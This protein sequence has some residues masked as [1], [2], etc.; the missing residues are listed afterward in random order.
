MKLFLL[1]LSILA[2]G[3][4]DREFNKRVFSG[5]T[6]E[7][8]CFSNRYV[9]IKNATWSNGNSIRRCQVDLTNFMKQKCQGESNCHYEV[10]E[11]NFND[12]STGGVMRLDVKY[13]C[14]KCDDTS[15]V[16]RSDTDW[17]YSFCKFSDGTASSNNCPN[18]TF[19][20]NHICRY[21]SSEREINEFAK[22]SARQQRNN[23]GIDAITV[24]TGNDIRY[25]GAPGRD[26]CVFTDHQKKYDCEKRSFSDDWTCT[27][28]GR[29][30]A[31][32][33]ASTGEYLNRDGPK[34][35]EERFGARIAPSEPTSSFSSFSRPSFAI[36][37]P[38][39]SSFSGRSPSW[40][41]ETRGF[42]RRSFGMNTASS[43]MGPS[44]SFQMR[45]SRFNR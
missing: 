10:N 43:N 19:E 29:V 4:A 2:L 39:I 42:G 24:F 14:R 16:I 15:E 35:S 22:S 12:C 37:S 9:Y 5:F 40:E 6:F 44:S 28:N 21:C 13:E 36:S 30:K 17:N 7:T 8:N 1:V 32:H 11:K 20:R 41:P 26:V 45:G 31:S 33:K 18:S 3:S 25:D 27:F 23:W 34:I 38:A